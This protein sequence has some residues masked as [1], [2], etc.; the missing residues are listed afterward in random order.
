M[1][2]V[3]LGGV[4]AAPAMYVPFTAFD[5]ASSDIWS[6]LLD[7]TDLREETGGT[8]DPCYLVSP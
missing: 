5:G 2:R 8:S 6:C 7:G 3:R 1:G 4:A